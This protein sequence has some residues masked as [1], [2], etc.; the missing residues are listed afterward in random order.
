MEAAGGEHGEESEG[1]D[2]KHFRNNADLC[3]EIK[4]GGRSGEERVG[5]VDKGKARKR[6]GEKKE[7]PRGAVWRETNEAPLS[8][9]EN[10]NRF[11]LT[12]FPPPSSRYSLSPH[13]AGTII[14]RS[15]HVYKQHHRA[16][17]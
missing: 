2:V 17:I 9:P 12:L 5:G 14:A 13:D 11:S 4:H 1:Q 7:P 3:Y 10:G 15:F 8:A 16:S 6:R